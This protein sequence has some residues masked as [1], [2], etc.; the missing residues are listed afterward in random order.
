[1]TELDH[2]VYA[3]GDLDAARRDFEDHTGVLPAF[4]GSH[5]GMGTHNALAS[6]GTSYVELIAPDPGQPA[7]AGPR[8]FGIDELDGDG[9]VAFAV[10]PSGGVTIEELVPRARASGHD[11]GEPIPMSRRQP[12]GTE[13]HWR[14]TMPTGAEAG[15]VPFLIDWG[16]TPTPNTT[17][18]AGL[19]LAEFVVRHPDPATLTAIYGAL[20]LP[21]EPQVADAAALIAT[22][23]GP[24][25][26]IELGPAARS[27]RIE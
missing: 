5:P 15:T 18:P 1:M 12:D 23:R 8:P 14:L 10:R 7:P 17:A 26:N 22:I 27:R 11:P 13:L 2:L 20:D 3:V 19:E 25:G 21:L 4:G 6:L 24:A 9:L 16:T